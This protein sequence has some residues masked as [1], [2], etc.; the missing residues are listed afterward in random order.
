MRMEALRSRAVAVAVAFALVA[1]L[2]AGIAAAQGQSGTTLT[3]AKSAD[4]HWQR[5]FHWTIAKSVTPDTLNM[6]R[7]DSG[8][9]VYTVTV[10]KDGGTD[11][12]YASGSICVTNGG[13]FATENLVILDELQYK[14]GA[15]QF[16]TLTTVAVDLSAKPVLAPGESYCYPY[17]V[18]FTPVD[19]A[20]YRNVAHVTITNHAGWMPGGNNCPGPDLCPFG[21]DP[22]A[23]FGVPSAPDVLVNDSVDV[24]DT[25]GSSWTFDAGGSVSYGRTFTCDGDRGAHGNTAT[26]TQTGQF[27]TAAVAV[28]CFAI[29]V[30]KDAHTSL[31][32]T[33]SWT[34][35]KSADASALTLAVGEQF[36]VNY[37]VQLLATS[38]DSDWAVDGTIYVANPAPMA[39]PLAAVTD[40]VSGVGAATVTCP[41]LVVPSG[42]TL[43]CTYHLALPDATA[44]VNTVTATLQNTPSGTTD[45]TF[46]LPF[47]FTAPSV[48]KIDECI[49][50]T[51]TFADGPQ[52]TRVCF[53]DLPKTFTYARTI[54]PYDACGAYK[55]EN[56]AS[57]VGETTG[58]TGSK[59][60]TV[61]VNVPCAT[62]CT[63]TQ[64][65]WKTHSEHGPAPYDDTWAQIGADTI[66]Y[67]SG[68]SWYQ[69]LWTTPQGGNAY[70][71]LA[72]QYIAARLNGLNGAA[73][74]PAV[75]A[76]LAWAEE[77][78]NEKT[79][80]SKLSNTVR[81]MA[82]AYAALLDQYNNGLAVDGPPHCS[83]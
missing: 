42:A 33:F 29:G 22:K 34:V 58:A 27:A 16:Q 77:F 24:T 13:S 52:G 7:G 68:Q 9:V 60:V 30:T 45:F 76:A 32:R 74:T 36:T 67:Y 37:A 57:F 14:V 23:D 59:T 70:Y 40:V 56:T 1:A 31:K 71:I 11:T 6:F 4:G 15:G 55:V 83:E 73:S 64:G 61:D 48:T 79:P 17:Q 25:N 2:G 20:V 41:S 38:V 19:G 65:Y 54:G 3:A 8:G 39:A 62:G 63:L 82:L 18:A 80:T 49:N 51:D 72:H 66:F 12:I 28:N 78:F 75:D 50:V 5:E 69:V 21:P 35:Q 10:T 44:R 43:A 53:G 81:N 47:D 26:I 46:N